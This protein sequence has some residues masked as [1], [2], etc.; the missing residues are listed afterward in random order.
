MSDKINIAFGRVFKRLRLERGWTHV[1][2]NADF[3]F[4]RRYLCDVEHGKRNVSLDF[5]VKTANM[6]GLKVYELIELVE[7]EDMK[8]PTV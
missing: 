1:S 4:G 3:G 6:F 2:V 5:I 8:M 7:Q